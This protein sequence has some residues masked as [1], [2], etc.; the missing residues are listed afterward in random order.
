MGG[1]FLFNLAGFLL[2]KTWPKDGTLLK[3]ELR[4]A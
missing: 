3:K 1:E 2:L 4:G